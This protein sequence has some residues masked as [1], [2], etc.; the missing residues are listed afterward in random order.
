MIL[1]ENFNWVSHSFSKIHCSIF[2]ITKTATKQI[3]EIFIRQQKFCVVIWFTD[4]CSEPGTVTHGQKVPDVGPYHNGDTILFTCKPGYQ[5][6]GEFT[7]QCTKGQFNR[8]ISSCL[9]D[10]SGGLFVWFMLVKSFECIKDLS[11]S[12][13]KIWPLSKSWALSS[14]PHHCYTQWKHNCIHDLYCKTGDCPD[15]GPMNN[16][17]RSPA[18]GPYPNGQEF[19]H[20]CNPGYE[21]EGDSTIQ[22]VDGLFNKPVPKCVQFNAGRFSVP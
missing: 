21:L 2:Q 15:P 9:R 1:E 20:T 10:N 5:L 7:I 14:S 22:C 6:H 16:G 8:P 3:I 12:V 11:P 18:A 13:F 19:Q 4:D 17:F